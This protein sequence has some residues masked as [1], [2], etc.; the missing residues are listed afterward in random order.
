MENAQEACVVSQ[1][2]PVNA[3]LGLGLTEP[4]QSTKTEEITDNVKADVEGAGAGIGAKVEPSEL[5]AGENLKPQGKTVGEASVANSEGERIEEGAG[6]PEAPKKSEEEK[7][8]SKGNESSSDPK[9]EPSDHE[10][11]DVFAN[12]PGRKLAD[13]VLKNIV[14]S[15]ALWGTDCDKQAAAASSLMQTAVS[16][17]AGKKG[18]DVTYSTVLTPEHWEC[19]F[20]LP[21]MCQVRP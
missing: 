20:K 2:T 14:A 9:V 1:P 3:G 15:S 7:E 21:G 18:S 19:V 10:P 4:L 17:L 12:L 16:G 6:N 13:A 5:A 8:N 11:K